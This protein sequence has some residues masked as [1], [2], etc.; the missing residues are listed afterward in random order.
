MAMVRLLRYLVLAQ[1]NP[2]LHH[3]EAKRWFIVSIAVSTCVNSILIL[4]DQFSNIVL[5]Q[6]FK[7]S[8]C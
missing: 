4:L 7:N 5:P 2:K 1:I 3:K 8:S 6:S